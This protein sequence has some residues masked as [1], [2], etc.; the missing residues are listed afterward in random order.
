MTKSVPGGSSLTRREFVI[1]TV[2]T[3]SAALLARGDAANAAADSPGSD[4]PM[5]RHDPALSAEFPVSG[6][7]ATKPNVVWSVDLGGPAIPSEQIVIRDVTG[8]GHEEILAL[9]ADSVVCRDSYGKQLWKLESFLSPTIID[10]LDFVGDGSRGILLT[11]TRAGRVD[12]FMVNGRTGRATH[13]WRDE[14]NFGGHTRI[15]RFVRDVAGLQIAATSSGQTPPAPHGGDVRLVSFEDGIDHPRFR[16]GEHVTGVFYSP[17]ILVADLNG[18][19]TDEIVVVSHEQIRA[20]DP[21]KGGQTFFAGY[22]PSIRTYMATVAAVRLH[23]EDPCP[24]LVMINPSLP[25]IKAVAQDGRSFARELW[26]VVI[27]GSEDQYQKLVAVTAAGTSLVY[28]PDNDGHPLLFVSVRNEHGDGETRLVIFDARNG[29]R[30]AELPAAEILS[31]DDLD[32]DGRNE[33]LLRRG[34]ELL[35]CR[36]QS[37]EL[38]TLWQ[39][40]DVLPVLKSLPQG[41]DPQLFS[42][43][44]PIAKGNATVWREREGSSQFLLRF[45]DAVYS[46]RLTSSGIVRA[47]VITTH[48]ALGNDSAPVLPLETIVRDGA[49]L[50]TLVDG[51]EVARYAVPSPTTYL[52]PPPLVAELSGKRRILVRHSAGH[53]LLCSADGRSERIFLERPHETAELHVDQ[54]GMMPL[55]CDM[56]GDGRNEVVATVSD[57]TGKPACVILDSDGNE[58]LRLELLPGMTA[59]NRGPTGRLG[60][61]RG[62]WVLLRMSG[63]GADHERQFL[64]A[65]YDGRT[66]ELLWVRNDYG[67]YGSNPVVF[68]PHFPSAVLD[69]DGDGADDWLVCSENFYGIISVRDNKDLVGPVVL[70]DALAGH[71]TAY[72]YPSVAALEKD[73]KPFVVHHSA[74]AL[75]LLTDLEGRPAWHFGMTRDTAGQWGQFADMD[76]DGRREFVH[77][78]P[79]GLLRGFAPGP[80]TRCPTCPPETTLAEIDP[81]DHRWDFDPGR[82]IS[83]I[84]TADLD[85]DGRSELLLGCDDGSLYAVGER[86]GKPYQLWS[87]AFGRR[88][89]EPILADLDGDGRPE[90]LVTTEDGRL[91]CLKSELP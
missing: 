69:Y 78:Q 2:C 45:P 9:S 67:L 82:P 62:R 37:G 79:D 34:S 53:Y 28:D 68:V 44:S 83:R 48:E 4:W 42:G 77:A 19:G 54:Y 18:D 27:G 29:E 30:L 25:G 66:G 15:G 84:I 38:K 12:T 90:I 88:V 35:I 11:S 10:I 58:K 13:L 55:I 70:S 20:F 1:G 73:G 7:L 65:A 46:C 26:R 31:S 8:D 43:S 63:E 36:W 85:G 40:A 22:G 80:L 71:W 23:P 59:L 72:S 47:E 52:A 3:G 64:V 87:V 60:P 16:V 41:G 24:A 91:H 14:N 74:F 61:G 76:G 49:N 39:Q 89:G 51:V 56:D 33:F 86:N 50:V 57:E 5:Y 21:Q 75:A 81:S 6:G 32:G 17:L